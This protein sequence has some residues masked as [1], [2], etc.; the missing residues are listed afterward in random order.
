MVAEVSQKLIALINL[1][2][3]DSTLARIAAEKK[4]SESALTERFVQLEGLRKELQNKRQVV[5]LERDKYDKEENRLKDESQKLV[6]RRKALSTFSNYKVQQSAQKEIEAS[7]KQLSAQEEKLLTTLEEVEKLETEFQ[8]LSEQ[9]SKAEEE[10][11]A[12]EED[13]RAKIATLE[14]RYQEKSAN[15]SQ[16]ASQVKPDALVHY[17]RI[18][19]RYPMDPVVAIQNGACSGCFVQ[20]AAQQQVQVAR[21]VETVLCRGCARILYLPEQLGA[22]DASE[23]TS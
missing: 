16:V 13:V 10:Y 4:Q 3:L 9:A 1:G 22:G 11:V 14:E 6:D 15:R 2:K 21:A 5:E 19:E 23:A 8:T 12:F 17:E 7:A 18:R 20:V